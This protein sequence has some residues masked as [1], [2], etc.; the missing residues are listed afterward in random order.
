M[1]ARDITNLCSNEAILSVLL[2]MLSTCYV[3]RQ[4]AGV[5]AAGWFMLSR[6]ESKMP[7]K[8]NRYLLKS[9]TDLGS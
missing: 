9:R 8:V 7:R 3:G 2:R 6:Y 4:V 5:C 1:S